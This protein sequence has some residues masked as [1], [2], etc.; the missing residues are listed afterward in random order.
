MGRK[1]MEIDW[2]RELGDQLDWHWQHR[3]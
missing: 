1:T 3:L 2:A